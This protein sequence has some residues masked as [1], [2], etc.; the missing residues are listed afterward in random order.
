MEKAIKYSLGLALLPVFVLMVLLTLNVYWFG[1]DTLGGANQIALLLSAAVVSIIA[2][3]KGMN[4]F[5]VREGILKSIDTAMPAM[6]ILLL[7]GSLAGTWMVSGV[8]PTMVYYGLMIVHPPVF[9][10]A[11]VIVTAIVSVST[12]S[13][14]STVATIGVAL[15]GIGSALG[16]SEGLVA[17]AIV[18]GSYFGD[19][20][21]PLSDTTNLAPAMAGT[22]LFTHVR[23]MLYTTVPTMLLTLII[24]AIIGFNLEFKAID[25]NIA[26]VQQSILDSF[27][28]SPW[29]F[30]VPIVLFAVI[31]L[32]LPPL[33]SLLFGTLLGG[34]FA[35]W[36]Q[37]E[38]MAQIGRGTNLWENAYKSFF[39]A[40]FGE[41]RI[42]ASSPIIADLFHSKGMQGMLNTIW[43]IISAMV[44]GGALEA[45]GM[46]KRITDA[47][48]S[49]I[50][51]TFSLVASTVG[52]CMFFNLTTSD[53]YIAIVVPG[54]MYAEVYR[55]KGLKPEVLSRTL[56][57]AGT[58]TSVLIPWNTCGATQSTVLG[59][60]VWAYAPYAFFNIISPLMTMLVAAL[61]YKIRRIEPEKT[62][63]DIL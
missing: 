62:H 8:I 40:M 15:M 39:K 56:E 17:G 55:E 59:V 41:V 46:L 22:D 42:E 5:K 52:T 26:Q 14:W 48:I 37:P 33:P 13:S 30:L 63:S 49:R 38:I 28:V 7:I 60:S 31:L 6:L 51:S 19:K 20:I 18:S 2:R 57:D 45:S 16:I 23:Y 47:I 24:F 44:F 34:I 27:N 25:A 36:F 21:S 58:V 53:Q 54:K 3:A 9:L 12:G 29:L 32:K 35:L 1:D 50:K 10:V 11:T 43:L 61:N 4:W